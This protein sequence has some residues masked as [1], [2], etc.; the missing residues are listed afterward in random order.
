VCVQ[1]PPSLGGECCDAFVRERREVL[2]AIDNGADV[3]TAT[4]ACGLSRQ[5]EVGE[6]GTAAVWNLRRCTRIWI[7]YTVK[8]N[9]IYLW[10]VQG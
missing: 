6:K 2:R 9:V 3:N 1:L 7:G 4:A 10:T 8:D 5:R